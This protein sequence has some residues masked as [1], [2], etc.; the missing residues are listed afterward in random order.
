MPCD[1]SVFA[2]QAIE[3]DV[4]FRRGLPVDYLTYMGAAFAPENDPAQGEASQ[5]KGKG[6][7]VR[8]RPLTA[9]VMSI[10]MRCASVVTMQA[11]SASKGRAAKQQQF[12]SKVVSLLHR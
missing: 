1:H 4:E 12:E 8:F 10:L 5:G 11:S 9:V 2:G 7:K 6:K 3:E